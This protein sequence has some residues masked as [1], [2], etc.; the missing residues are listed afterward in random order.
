MEKATTRQEAAVLKAEKAA[1]ET[2]TT[3]R[4]ECQSAISKAQAQAQAAIEAA[5]AQAARYQ[6]LCDELSTAARASKPTRRTRRKTAEETE[7][8]KERSL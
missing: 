8:G 5:Q 7:Q 2:L 3:V 6:A 4:N 1:Q